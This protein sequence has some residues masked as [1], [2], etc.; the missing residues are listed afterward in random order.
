[1]DHESM[2]LRIRLL[3]C[4]LRLI[5]NLK[6]IESSYCGKEETLRNKYAFQRCKLLNRIKRAKTRQQ[7]MRRRRVFVML[8]LLTQSTNIT[9]RI[10][11]RIW[12][13]PRNSDL[14]QDVNLW[15]DAE[16]LRNVRMSRN[17]FEYL[18]NELG[19]DLQK[20]RTKF[21]YKIVDFKIC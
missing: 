3:L 16:W 2:V 21:R 8:I 10:H 12:N 17:T 18:C 20:Q 13:I 15:S 4:F 6:K 5:F 14:W 1:M 19:P 9:R 7:R 11:R